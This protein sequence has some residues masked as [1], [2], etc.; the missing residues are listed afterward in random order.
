MNLEHIFSFGPSDSELTTGQTFQGRVSQLNIYSR[1][2]PPAEIRS[3]MCGNYPAGDVRSWTDFRASIKGSEGVRDIRVVP[4]FLPRQKRTCPHDFDVNF[5]QPNTEHYLQVDNL[6]AFDAF[7]ITLWFNSAIKRGGQFLVSYLTD[8]SDNSILL[9]TDTFYFSVNNIVKRDTQTSFHDGK[10]H[11]IVFQWDTTRGSET[12][13]DGEPFRVE[14]THALGA[15]ITNAGQR[16]LIG[17]EQGMPFRLVGNWVVSNV[18]QTALAW[19]RASA[20]T[21]ASLSSISLTAC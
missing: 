12:W 20:G 21:V 3:L 18:A 16:F 8:T 14:P 4:S 2:L 15:T 11:H 17:Q 13:V 6:P 7:S 9:S 1:V 5:G 10:W 19:T